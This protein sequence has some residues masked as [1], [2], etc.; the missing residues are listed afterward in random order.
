M[1]TDPERRIQA[2]SMIEEAKAKYEASEAFADYRAKLV[3]ENVALYLIKANG[4]SP[5]GAACAA[6]AFLDE[7]GAGMPECTYL[8]QDKPREDAA[9]WALSANQVE[10]EAVLVAAIKELGQSPLIRRAA[11]RLA[12]LGWNKMG[13]ENREAFKAWIARGDDD[14]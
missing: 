12:A 4:V 7:Y 8:Y 13:L 3:A 1:Q 10:M 11:K 14:G 6:A 2:A 9:W 5:R